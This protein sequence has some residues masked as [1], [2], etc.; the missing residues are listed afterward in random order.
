MRSM[1]KNGGSNKIKSKSVQ[2]IC[3]KNKLGCREPGH[4]L[5]ENRKWQLRSSDLSEL[6]IALGDDGDEE[7]V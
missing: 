3:R 6:L 4:G 2:E 7:K 5:E 1:G